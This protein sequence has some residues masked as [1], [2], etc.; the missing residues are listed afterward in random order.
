MSPGVLLQNSPGWLMS[1]R[2]TCAR[3]IDEAHR[4]QWGPSRE[5]VYQNRPVEHYIFFVPGYVKKTV[6]CP[7]FEKNCTKSKEPQPRFELG[8]C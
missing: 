5:M 8:T 3:Y 2:R 4:V 7:T 6:N 1:R